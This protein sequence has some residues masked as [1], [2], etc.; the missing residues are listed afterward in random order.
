MPQTPVALPLIRFWR[1][2]DAGR[3]VASSIGPVIGYARW[4]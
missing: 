4:Y 1:D 3:T 2:L